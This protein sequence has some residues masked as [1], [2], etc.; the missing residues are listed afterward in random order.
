MIEFREQGRF[1]ESLDIC[2]QLARIHPNL[3][4]AAYTDA[5]INSVWLKH[6][7]DAIGYAQTALTLGGNDF[8]I[9]NSLAYAYCEIGQWDQAR[10]YGL[11]VLNALAHD[12]GGEPIP[13]LNLPPIPPLPNLQTRER[14]IIAFSLFGDDSKYCETSILNVQEQPNIYPY[15]TCRFYVDGS[16]P[17][18][19][20]SRLQ[21]GGAQIVPVNESVAQWPGSMWRF[22]ALNDPL[23]HRILFRD[24]D[25]V[26]SQREAGAVEQWLTSGKRFHVMRDWGSHTALILAGMWGVVAGSLPPLGQ[27]ME[28]FLSTPIKSRHFADQIFLRQYVWPY[29][30][31]SMMQHDSIFGFM[32]SIPFPDGDGGEDFHRVGYSEGG[33]YFSMKSDLPDGSKIV[34]G[35]YLIKKLNDNHSQSN[36]ICTY[37]GIVKNSMVK[38]YI[39]VCYA[40]QIQQGMAYV[41]LIGDKTA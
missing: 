36:L 22:L 1:M 16:V 11:R 37:P 9:S 24:A 25:S 35:L 33:G 10:R 28:R 14:N 41:R 2:L 21:N 38:A 4:A 31:T 30:R 39:P 13:L 6:W 32:N 15:W 17:K 40:R 8:D 26:I 20:I 3:M 27:L 19:V 34:W 5:A 7:Q 29:A 23:A 18:G 12:T